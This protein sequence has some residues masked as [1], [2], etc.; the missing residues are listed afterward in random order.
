MS[1]KKEMKIMN[2][3]MS[4]WMIIYKIMNSLMMISDK[5]IILWIN[6]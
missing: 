5:G 3:I 1:M 4:V 2:L 6:L